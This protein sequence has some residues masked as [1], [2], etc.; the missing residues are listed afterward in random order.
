VYGWFLRR[1]ESDVDPMTVPLVWH[2]FAYRSY[3]ALQWVDGNLLEPRLPADLFYNL[4]ISGRT[5]A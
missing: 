5:S 1:L 3:L 4:M 2:R